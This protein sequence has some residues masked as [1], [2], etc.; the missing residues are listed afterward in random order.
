MGQIVEV[1]FIL[2]SEC[3]EIL[4]FK[5]L[6]RLINADINAIIKFQSTGRYYCYYFFI[7]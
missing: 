5:Y 6:K 3:F 4:F 1:N 7:F 2:F